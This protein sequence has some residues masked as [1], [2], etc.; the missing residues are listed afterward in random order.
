[1]VL[2]EG[3]LGEGAAPRNGVDEDSPDFNI[4]A[5]FRA[6]VCER[7]Q[8]NSSVENS[9]FALQTLSFLICS[10]RRSSSCFS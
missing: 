8:I 7:D 3:V 9:L 10:W 5:F 4:S 6:C 1:M 2:C